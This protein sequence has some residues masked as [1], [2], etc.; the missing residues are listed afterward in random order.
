MPGKSNTLWRVQGLPGLCIPLVKTCEDSRN[1]LQGVRGRR[2]AHDRCPR[3]HRGC[4]L[5]RPVERRRHGGLQGQRQQGAERDQEAAQGGEGE[6][7]AEAGRPDHQREPRPHQGRGYEDAG[8]SGHQGV[9]SHSQ[10]AR[11]AVPPLL[12]RQQSEERRQALHAVGQAPAA[13][14]G[15]EVRVDAVRD[16]ADREEGRQG[17]EQE[18]TQTHS[19]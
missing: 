14:A 7:R 5:S 8:R 16:Q 1:A 9:P 12:R 19:N 18:V 4:H 15:A 10:P 6:E 11:A 17:Q 13:E 2:P 3:V